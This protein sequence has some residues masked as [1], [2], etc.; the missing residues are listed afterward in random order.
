VTASTPGRPS[1]TRLL[2]V[3]HGESTWNAVGRWQ[4][5]ADP[6]LSPAGEAQARSAAA[7]VMAQGPFSAVAT[8]TLRRAR[9][10]GELIAADASIELLDPLEDLIERSAGEWEGLM[11]PEIEARFPGWLAEYR[12]P[13]GY[14]PDDEIIGR[15]VRALR[16]IRDLAGGTNV[17]VV[18]HGGVINALER[19]VGESWRQLTN[20]E[21][22]WFEFEADEGDTG[23]VVPVGDR[24]HLLAH[25]AIVVETDSRYA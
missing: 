18:S 4:G 8:S 16:S 13:P 20:L 24:V 22:R 21:A 19:R 7:G 17:L 3:R 10:T 11:R 25:D 23:G 14:E 9:H 5:R 15:A 2:L 6:P 1:A 12:R